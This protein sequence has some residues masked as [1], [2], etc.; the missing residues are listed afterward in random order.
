MA[1]VILSILLVLSIA[2]TAG[3]S[4]WRDINTECNEKGYDTP[5]HIGIGAATTGLLLYYLPK[6]WGFWRY[7]AAFLTPVAIAAIKETTDKNCYWED[8][9]EYAIGSALSV[10]ISFAF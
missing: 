7:T 4:E 3:A 9:G 8:V 10:S 5:I 2:A 1:K 6:D